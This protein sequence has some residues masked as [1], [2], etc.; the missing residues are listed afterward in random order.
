M[1]KKR[2]SKARLLELAKKIDVQRR[3]A[4]RPTLPVNAHAPVS[5][6]LKEKREALERK[7]RQKREWDKD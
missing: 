2:A 4:A 5:K 3:R 6:S 1:K 7:A